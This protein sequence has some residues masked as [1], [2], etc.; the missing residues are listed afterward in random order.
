MAAETSSGVSIDGTIES[1]EFQYNVDS[2]VLG[3]ADEM[4]IGHNNTGPATKQVFIRFRIPSTDELGIPQDAI[5]VGGDIGLVQQSHVGAPTMTIDSYSLRNPYSSWNQ[6]ATGTKYD[7]NNTWD[8]RVS[9]SSPIWHKKL[10]SVSVSGSSGVGANDGDPLYIPLD[11]LFTGLDPVSFGDVVNIMLATSTD[12]GVNYRMYYT[13]I[14]D[15]SGEYPLFRADYLLPRPT[16]APIITVTPDPDDGTTGFVN[17]TTVPS[18]DHLLKYSIAW[19]EETVGTTPAQTDNTTDI[20]DV[21]RTQIPLSELTGAPLGDGTSAGDGGAGG[22]VDNFSFRLWAEDTQ[23]TDANGQAS[24]IVSILRPR[25][26]SAVINDDGLV[27]GTSIDSGSGN[28]EIGKKY[29]LYVVADTTGT[30]VEAYHTDGHFKHVWVNWDSGVSDIF[31]T[32][33][34]KYTMNTAAANSTQLGGKMGYIWTTNGAKVVKIRI[35]DV[36]GWQSNHF[37]AT[38]ITGNAPHPAEATPVAVVTTSRELA[39]SAISG[40]IGGDSTNDKIEATPTNDCA[41]IVNAGGSYAVGSDRLIHKY[42]WTIP[43]DGSNRNVVTTGCLDINN[44]ILDISSKRLY[45]A[46]SKASMEG[47]KIRLV[48][49]ASFNSSGTPISDEVKSTFVDGYY[50]YVVEDISCGEDNFTGEGGNPTTPSTHTGGTEE[51]FG[52]GTD[53]FFKRVDF[54]FV[55]STMGSLTAHNAEV[56]SVWANK[57]VSD[58]KTVSPDITTVVDSMEGLCVVPALCVD[59]ASA[60]TG[61]LIERSAAS[62]D[63]R[64]DFESTTDGRLKISSTKAN[65]DWFD[66]GF[67]IGDKVQVYN[68]GFPLTDGFYT[69]AVID[70]TDAS[71]FDAYMI[72]EE[73]HMDSDRTGNAVA[74]LITTKPSLSL[75]S[76]Y[77]EADGH[78]VSCVVTDNKTDYSVASGQASSAYDNKVNL[79]WNVPLNLD[80]DAL[81]SNGDIAILSSS[82]DRPSGLSSSMSLGN[83]RFPNAVSQTKFGMPTISMDLQILS[84]T[85]LRQIRSLSTGGFT[86]ALHAMKKIDNPANNLQRYMMVLQDCTIDQD[87]TL[88][89][90]YNASLTFIARY[91]YLAGE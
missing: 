19:V 2:A 28:V 70:T 54:A 46:C 84:Q 4:R 10:G 15:A 35:E 72:M 82:L 3:S 6:D 77:Y 59:T 11:G 25:I 57:D 33:Y 1:A 74:K 56:Y 7:G 22:M 85:G 88:G 40:V 83:S 42:S 8:I 14:A 81:A 44:D 49:L 71:G 80:L 86:Y 48:G 9:E 47:T 38:N 60:I 58:A 75:T 26:H 87:P 12:I 62:A 13:E 32:D 91:P 36:D 65:H 63:N 66:V 52:D 23:N 45:A 76:W 27:G 21:G 90:T 69:I 68:T 30:D 20:V 89:N 5:L 31:P 37:A 16:P 79:R 24:N 73:E 53:N 61:R 18:S 50:D 51:Q 43:E 64:M 41:I 67:A 39:L 17:I 29:Y 34:S 78:S 55:T